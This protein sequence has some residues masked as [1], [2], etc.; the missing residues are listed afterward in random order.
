ML[1]LDP[2]LL[3]TFIECQVGLRLRHPR[4]VGPTSTTLSTDPRLLQLADRKGLSKGHKAFVLVHTM[5]Y[6]S[7][8][9]L[10]AAIKKVCGM[11][12]HGNK[13]GECKEGSCWPCV[14]L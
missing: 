8:G 11:R 10:T 9:T 14:P 7:G 4:L 6:L 12:E 2:Q 1:R 3:R 13:E 5:P